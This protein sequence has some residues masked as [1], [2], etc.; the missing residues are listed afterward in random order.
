MMRTLSSNTRDQVGPDQGVVACGARPV[1]LWVEQRAVVRAEG[2][3][4]QAN[5]S[6]IQHLHVAWLVSGKRLPFTHCPSSLSALPG[7]H[8]VSSLSP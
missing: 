7:A 2:S 8:H 6:M 4:L 3:G 1:A 5:W